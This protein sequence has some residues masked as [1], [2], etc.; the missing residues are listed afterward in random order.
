ML[1]KVVPARPEDD[2]AGGLAPSMLMIELFPTPVLPKRM[3]LR[4]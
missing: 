4:K 2:V 1:F 3:T